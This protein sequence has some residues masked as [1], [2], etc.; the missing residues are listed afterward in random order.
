V[1][2]RDHGVEGQYGNT[3]AERQIYL[4]TSAQ[5]IGVTRPVCGGCQTAFQQAAQAGNRVIVVADPGTAF[6][7]LPDGT[8]Q[9]R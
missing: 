8:Q 1:D 5:A 4:L 7:F 2:P 3:H 9:T 6:V